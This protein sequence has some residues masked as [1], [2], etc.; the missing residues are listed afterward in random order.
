MSGD[1]CGFGGRGG[2]LPEGSGG[3]TPGGMPCGNGGGGIGGNGGG[4]PGGIGGCALDKFG[5]GWGDGGGGFGGAKDSPFAA[6]G[7]NR[8]DGG[9][10]GETFGNVLPSALLSRSFGSGMALGSSW[11]LLA[12]GTA[13]GAGVA[14]GDV[15][16]AF[17]GRFF[18]PPIGSGGVHNFFSSPSARLGCFRWSGS[19]ALLK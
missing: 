13:L 10:F 6:L 15:I 16:D 14:F 17:S 3:C 2:G 12:M 11:L 1:A 19:L 18:T 8:G 7:G 9:V 4:L 5:G